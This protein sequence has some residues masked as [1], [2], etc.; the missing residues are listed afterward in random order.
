[1]N[2]AT[3][4]SKYKKAVIILSIA[5]FILFLTFFACNM[6]FVVD[7]IMFLKTPNKVYNNIAVIFFAKLF[8]SGLIF[9]YVICIIIFTW[10]SVLFLLQ[11]IKLIK[12]RNLSYTKINISPFIHSIIIVAFSLYPTIINLCRI[13]VHGFNLNFFI[14]FMVG[15]IILTFTIFYIVYHKLTIKYQKTGL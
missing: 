8:T 13:I 15:T 14:V 5:C 1:M 11:G 7:L 2:S 9:F 6:L 4:N 3:V 10:L 12:E